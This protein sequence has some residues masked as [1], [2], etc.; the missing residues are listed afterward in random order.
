[1][2]WS[3]RRTSK[4]CVWRLMY[5]WTPDGKSVLP[6]THSLNALDKGE[7]TKN[8][9]EPV[10]HIPAEKLKLIESPLNELKG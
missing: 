1:M 7:G 10:R 5:E 3:K 8:L 4:N 2:K 9:Q 6:E